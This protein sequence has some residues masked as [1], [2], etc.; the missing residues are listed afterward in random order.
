MTKK[1]SGRYRPG[2]EWTLLPAWPQN[3]WTSLVQMQDD[4]ER[5]N[6]RQ[7]HGRLRRKLE[8]DFPRD[9]SKRPPGTDQ[10]LKNLIAAENEL[11][12]TQKATNNTGIGYKGKE[13][14]KENPTPIG[15]I[16]KEGHSSVGDTSASKSQEAVE[17]RG[18]TL[19]RTGSA[20]GKGSVANNKEILRR[21]REGQ[22]AK[23]E[24]KSQS[25]NQ[26]PNL[27][28]EYQ[29]TRN[30]NNSQYPDTGI[31]GEFRRSNQV[32]NEER[33]RMVTNTSSDPKRHLD[34]KTG[35]PISTGKANKESLTQTTN[36]DKGKSAWSQMSNSQKADAIANV[37][38]ALQKLDGSKDEIHWMGSGW[39]GIGSGGHAGY[40]G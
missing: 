4:I 35:K 38:F 26:Q 30:P 28:K 27:E 3:I 24:Q 15:G 36:T 19:N 1:W 6:R 10:R 13:G 25:L 34:A 16:I 33:Q 9:G 31:R 20:G 40:V 29:N 12:G 23:V 37:A 8:K 18:H 7:E 5:G 39:G 32:W 2:L 11:I 21:M 14:T 17:T 22:A